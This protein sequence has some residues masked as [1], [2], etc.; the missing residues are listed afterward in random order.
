VMQAGR[1]AKAA[2]PLTAIAYQLFLSSSGRGE[3]RL[4]DSQVIRSYDLLN[5]ID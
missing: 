4:D 1:D 2:L 5:G 3:G